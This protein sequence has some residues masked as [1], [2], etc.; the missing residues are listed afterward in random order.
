MNLFTCYLSS[1]YPTTARL[2]STMYSRTHSACDLMI[3]TVARAV[4][5]FFLL[6]QSLG[7]I[8]AKRKNVITHYTLITFIQILRRIHK[9]S[10]LRG[11]IPNTKDN[12]NVFM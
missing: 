6:F 11:R 7:N 4:V 2:L 5:I 3:L 8:L 9:I 12:N 10:V 1:S